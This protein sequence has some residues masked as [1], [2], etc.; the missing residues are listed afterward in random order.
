MESHSPGNGGSSHL[1]DSNAPITAEIFERM[2]GDYVAGRLDDSQVQR[3]EIAMLAN[4]Q[5]AHWVEAELLLRAGVQH[6]ADAEP[7]LFSRQLSVAD[8]PRS[9]PLPWTQRQR[10]WR[11]G[12]ALAASTAAAVL[13]WNAHGQIREL[14][15]ELHALQ[16]P[17]ADVRF[18]RLDTMRSLDSATIAQLRTP[19]PGSRVL[20]EI[21]A[22]SDTSPRRSL[23]LYSG[24]RLVFANHSAITSADGFVH[25]DVPGAV[26]AEGDYRVQVG[27][28]D[29]TDQIDDEYH[30]RIVGGDEHVR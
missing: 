26:L 17:N 7:E 20:V 4:P 23:R 5:F 8:A 2:I 21:P 18:L 3:F 9:T 14:R 27:S 30:F 13:L 10:R 25:L 11:V 22:G 6:L 15:M 16:Q 28:A 12:V 29:R 19:T 24:T 1:I